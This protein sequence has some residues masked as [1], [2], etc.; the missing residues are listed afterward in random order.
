MSFHSNGRIIQGLTNEPTPTTKVFNIRFVSENDS[1]CEGEYTAN[2]VVLD[3]PTCTEICNNGVDDDGDGLIDYAN[4]DCSEH[5]QTAEIQ[6][7]LKY[8]SSPTTTIELGAL[9][10]QRCLISVF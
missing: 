9:K 1:G 4:N 5:L 10:P 7:N 3:L 6:H 2:P 8:T